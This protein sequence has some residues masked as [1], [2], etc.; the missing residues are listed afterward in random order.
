MNL[1]SENINSILITGGS[2]F[3]GSNLITRLLREKSFKIYNLDKIN[4]ASN[5]KFFHD[6]ADS[7]QYNFLKVDLFNI[8][9][10]KNAIKFSNPDWFF[11]WLLKVM[12]INPLSPL[13]ILFK[14]M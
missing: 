3:I 11:I 5:F 6:Y 9:D 2:G 10:T 13:K 4:Y 7:N 12:L 14:V 1:F 8:E